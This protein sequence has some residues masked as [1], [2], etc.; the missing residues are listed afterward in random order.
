MANQNKKL[1]ERADF[2]IDIAKECLTKGEENQYGTLVGNFAKYKSLKSGG[3][4]FIL[5][6]YDG[7]HPYYSGFYSA[8]RYNYSNH[9]EAA[10]DILETIKKEIEQGWLTSIRGLVSAEIFSD[11]LEMADHLLDNSYKDAAAV[12]IGS[13]LEEHLRQLCLKNGLD[14]KITKGAGTIN[15]K[16]DALNNSLAKAGIYNKLD[17]KSV[18]ANLDLRN[19]AAHGHY[20]GY[21]IKQVKLMYDSVSDFLTR[22]AI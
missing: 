1:I 16:A 5:D 4:S 11:F 6:L 20:A 10:I 14:T 2:L 22:N 7:D 19:Q 8:L 18:T 3:L 9:I 17:Q 12:M 21:D 13:I 15:I